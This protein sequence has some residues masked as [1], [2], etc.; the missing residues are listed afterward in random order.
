MIL[1]DAQKIYIGDNE[2]NKVYKQNTLIYTSIPEPP[3][4]KAYY[5]FRLGA[6]I[7]DDTT[8]AIPLL[9][10]EVYS[11][12]VNWGDGNVSIVDN[13]SGQNNYIHDY[14]TQG[15][16]IIDISATKPNGFPGLN[17]KNY[18]L[19]EYDNIKAQKHLYYVDLYNNCPF[20]TMEG[21]FYGC[22][23]LDYFNARNFLSAT[24]FKDA[25]SGCDALSEF[26]AIS[27]PY[28]TNFIGA[29]EDCITLTTFNFY[30]D[31][32]AKMQSGENCFRGTSLPTE[33]WSSLLTSISSTN[34]NIGVSFNGGSSYRNSIGTSAYNYLVNQRN[35]IITDGGA[36]P[37]PASTIYVSYE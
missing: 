26:P 16:A 10:S 29:W 28:G 23:N 5:V 4:L 34:T 7:T 9:S 1:S 18:N 21:C 2:V 30:L 37:I 8:F 12:R 27:C 6:N 31:T 19:I 35:W 22:Y 20:I 13:L 24:N 25:W 33:T 32:F 15:V 36:E 14:G 11:F 17:F 3:G